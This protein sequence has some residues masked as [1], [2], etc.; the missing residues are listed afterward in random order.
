MNVTAISGFEKLIRV[1]GLVVNLTALAVFLY[2][3][4]FFYQV[5]L[6]NFMTLPAIPS[7]SLEWL[8]S[9]SSNPPTIS[10]AKALA[11]VWVC[12][13]GLAGCAWMSILGLRWA[14]HAALCGLET[15]K[16]L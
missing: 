11:M 2:G 1:G 16:K 5:A 3:S 10:S 6:E 13:L 15:L 7:L 4:N 14:Y 9:L 12:G 8:M